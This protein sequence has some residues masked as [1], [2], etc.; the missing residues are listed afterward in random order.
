MEYLKLRFLITGEPLFL[1]PILEKGHWKRAQELS[2]VDSSVWGPKAA[3]IKSY[4]GYYT[5]NTPECDSNLFF[6][7]FPAEVRTKLDNLTKIE[8]F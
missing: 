2:R 4:A 3:D 6:W 5:V 7:Y 8:A 1:T